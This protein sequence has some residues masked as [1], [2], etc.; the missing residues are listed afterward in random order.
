MNDSVVEI[1]ANQY[2]IHSQPRS[3][4]DC[5]FCKHHTMSIKADDTLAKCFHDKC[6][7]YITVHQSSPSY[8][9]SLHKAL[10]TVYQDF[11]KYFLSLAD[12]EGPN[13]YL[14]CLKKRQIHPQVLQDAPVGAIPP[15][16][17]LAR[18]L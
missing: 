11:H 15:G 12:E 13:V 10:E 17:D 7:R 14:Y 18:R 6:L 2:G 9:Q 16:Y 3:R 4:I 5:P 1:L 8:Q